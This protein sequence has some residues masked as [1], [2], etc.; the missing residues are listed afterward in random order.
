M[1][2]ITVALR[3]GWVWIEVR[4]N[5][6]G[7]R[8]DTPNQRAGL[9]LANT[10]ARLTRLYGDRHCFELR[11]EPGKGLTVAVGIPFHLASHTGSPG[12]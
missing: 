11:N 6:P 5:G 12:R 9:G 4:D 8:E 2:Q 7:L 3:E 1:I 10:R